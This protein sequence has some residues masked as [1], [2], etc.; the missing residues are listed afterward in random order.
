[1]LNLRRIFKQ[2]STKRQFSF[3]TGTHEE[4]YEEPS[5][6]TWAWILMVPFA[7]ILFIWWWMGRRPKQVEIEYP[8][9]PRESIPSAPRRPAEPTPASLRPTKTE[10][11]QP[12]P[13]GTEQKIQT[14]KAQAK[15]DNLQRID[16]IGPKISSLFREAGIQ[17]FED[18]AATDVARLQQILD[19]SGIRIAD[20]DTW[21]EQARYAASGDWQRLQEFQS[22]LKGGRRVD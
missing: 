13:S 20:P 3:F 14:R 15:A 22:Q 4:E 7:L 21:P 18:L 6:P 16:G 9:T 19:D 11:A 5:F 2:F 1:M 8:P 10:Q 12:A 17:T